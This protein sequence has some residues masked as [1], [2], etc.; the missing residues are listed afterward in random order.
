MNIVSIMGSPHGMKGTTGQL[1]SS[2][3]DGARQAGAAVTE[4]SLADVEVRP[5]NACDV[6]HR[7][8][9]CPIKDGF[10]DVQ[11]AMVDADAVI[12]A[13]PNY[14]FS[15]SAQMKAVMDRCCGLLHCQSLR[16]K[17][18]AAVVTGGGDAEEVERYM[19]RFLHVMGIWTAGS[20]G[21]VGRDLADAD[22]RAQRRQQGAELGARLV[23]AARNG[24]EFP[25]QAPERDAFFERMKQ[26]V[27]MRR[28]EWK[29][30]YDHWRAQG[31]L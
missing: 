9:Q 6:C 24:T 28:D 15:V 10:G 26:L 2:V 5:C 4:I 16:G 12:L 23:E 1:L 30:E 8:G 27:S 31:W 22:G 18:G 13:S 20:V 17:Y 3:L 19:L 21:A 7:T 25:E 11:R 29:H 14:I